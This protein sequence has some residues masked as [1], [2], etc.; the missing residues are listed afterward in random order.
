MEKDKKNYGKSILVVLLLLIT[1]VALVFATYAWARYTTTA[2]GNVQASIARWDVTLTSDSSR[3]VRQYEHVVKDKM[4]PGTEGQID[5]ALN[6]NDTDVNFDFEVAL[7][8]FA[9]MQKPAHV[10]FYTDA[11]KTQ[12][13]T[14]SSDKITG[15]VIV[16]N[17]TTG[18]KLATPQIKIG[19]AAPVDLTSSS[20]NL[21]IYWDWAYDYDS[22][23]A[24]KANY[25]KLQ[26]TDT[27]YADAVAAYDTQDTQ[28]ARD[29]NETPTEANGN[30]SNTT[31]NKAA[32][33]MTVNFTLT[34]TQTRPTPTTYGN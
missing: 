10:R 16:V 22:Y 14:S 33:S 9:N 2:S 21:S 30:G 32:K 34:A 31:M 25:T 13:I 7:N 3:F 1:M 8:D 28:D 5:I 26:S 27:G 17:A 6:A 19:N 23:G 24:N 11:N 18:Q 15:Q 29:F 20:G 12:E 4:A